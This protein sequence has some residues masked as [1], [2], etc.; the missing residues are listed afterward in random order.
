MTSDQT[1]D[2]L[3]HEG[4]GWQRVPAQPPGKQKRP[5]TVRVA[6][7]SATHPWRAI[8]AWVLFVTLCVMGGGMVGAKTL[9]QDS[10]PRTQSGQ[11]DRIETSGNFAHPSVENVLITARKGTLSRTEA[12]AA[13]AEV[14]KQMRAI[15]QVSKVDPVVVSA[16]GRALLVPVSMAGDPDTASERIAPLQKITAAVQKAH[17]DLRVEEVGGASLDAAISKTL[18]GDL[19]KAELISIPI[20]L[21]ILVVAF[22]ALIAAGIPLLLALS[23]VAAAIGLSAFASHLL[24]QS[25]ALSSVVLL[26]G[27]AVG[28][29]YSLFY[30]RREREERARG[31]D[32]LEAIEIAAETS[33]HSVVVSGIAVAIAM[34]GLLVARDATF[35]SMAVGAILVVVVAVIG[36]LTLLPALLA[37]LGR[38]V[39]RPK[40]PFLWRLTA[41]RTTEPRLWS[42]LLKPAL[43]RPGMSMMVSVLALLALALPA[44]G[45]TLKLP[46]ASD[47][48]RSIP[49]MNS[50]DRLT[51]SFPSS[52][53]THTVAIKAPASEL[54]Q[55][56]AAV[57]ALDKRVAASPLYAHDQAP[58]VRTSANGT[59]TTVNIGVNS[60][61]G[62]PLA[63]RSL[64]ELRN[65]LVPQTIGTVPHA[66]YAVGG[67]IGGQADFISSMQGSLPWVIGFVLALTLIVMLVTF[68][69]VAIAL[70]A[71]GLNLL[72][73]G[74]SFGIL[75]LV[76]QNHWAESLLGFHSIG[77]VVAWLPLFLFVVLFGLSMDYH[78]FVVSRI[79]EAALRGEPT[80]EAVRHGI[81]SSAGV[82]TSAAVVMVAVFSVFATLSTI[83][84]KELG[85]GLAAAILLDATVI[86]IVLLP[87]V[88]LL[89]GR[90]NWWAPAWIARGAPQVP[91]E[92]E[93][94]FPSRATV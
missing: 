67:D 36:S 75:V 88:M 46:T 47:L 42:A 69:S 68:R 25:D 5:A 84:M 94:V 18:G 15:A 86:R 83:D 19:H 32:R 53:E 82:V 20:T 51:A 14:T 54:P 43:R 73:A 1:Y 11:A 74:A 41:A 49:I 45:M 90:R 13:A 21:V 93:P 71:I 9:T 63:T 30:I 64:N 44:L 33:G 56:K 7:W 76:F 52:S 16:N 66:R 65:V 34:S 89:L 3:H 31:V 22:G 72:S 60:E 27:M 59:V 77:A 28:V 85:V 48:P 55:V 35:S 78:V 23:S 57:A 39:D 80:K 40:I 26:I 79:R 10:S 29:D 87:S 92:S 38:W 12:N 37:K 24:P 8:G 81:I 61:P 58:E 62:K 70:T 6:R 2:V 50:Y 91:Y 4:Q 17:S